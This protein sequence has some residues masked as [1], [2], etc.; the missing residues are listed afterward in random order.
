MTD[1]RVELKNVFWIGGSPCAGKSSIG[2]I[3]A[4]PLVTHNR[5]DFEAV[6]NLHIISES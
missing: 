5:K 1:L 4:I 6:E 3:L 2:E